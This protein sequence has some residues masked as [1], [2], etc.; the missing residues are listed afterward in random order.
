MNKK[1][2]I[3]ILLFIIVYFFKKTEK[4]SG[5]TSNLNI[6]MSSPLDINVKTIS[7]NTLNSTSR[8]NVEK[9]IKIGDR[10]IT[11]DD[12]LAL[13][14]LPLVF[15]NQMCLGDEC[16][17]PKHFNNL[18]K[19]WNYGTIIAF[20]GEINTIPK[21]W[22]LCDGTNGTPDLREKF[23]IGAGVKYKKGDTGGASEHKLNIDE[24]AEHNHNIIFPSPDI[25]PLDNSE[26]MNVGDIRWG[27]NKL[28]E[29]TGVGFCENDS[30]V[31]THPIDRNSV[32]E[33]WLTN[34]LPHYVK[35]DTIIQCK[36]IMNKIFKQTYIDTIKAVNFRKGVKAGG[37]NCTNT[38]FY[39]I[40]TPRWT[41]ENLEQLKK[42]PSIGYQSMLIKNKEY[43]APKSNND[44]QEDE[45][46]INDKNEYVD[47]KGA[48]FSDKIFPNTVG[49]NIKGGSGFYI[50]PTGTYCDS[51]ESCS[52]SK[53]L[54]NDYR[55]TVSKTIQGE[56]CQNWTQQSPH[57][58]TRTLENYP[59]SGLGDHNYCR[60]P[61]GESGPWCYTTKKGDER[62]TRWQLCDTDPPP[63]DIKPHNNMP[64][65]YRLIYIMRMNDP[66]SNVKMTSKSTIPKKLSVLEKLRKQI[67]DANQNPEA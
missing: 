51:I 63:I 37:M 14:S 12:I 3:G 41:P 25:I 43:I 47:E 35:A 39:S 8:I 62:G 4:F 49:V 38:C 46:T 50:G 9:K 1:I 30:R 66:P 61:D 21:N 33:E 60:N 23:I 52:S 20:S 56:T 6:K 31:N 29:E 64:A 54:G 65:Y 27:S 22:A 2:I 24:M 15:D 28:D 18:K 40:E 57:K 32:K 67:R 53:G 44:K 10:E 11:K 58:H 26:P 34:K 16:V 7:N 13:K 55:G 36:N 17:L 5:V 59:G 19:Y 48:Y 42:D 45:S